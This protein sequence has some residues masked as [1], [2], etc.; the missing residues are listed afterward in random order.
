M[1]ILISNDGATAHYYIRQGIAEAL[2]YAG[3]E[4]IIWELNK[5]PA[6]E[7]FDIFEPDLFITQSYNVNRAIYKNIIKRPQMKVIMKGSDNSAFSRSLNE[8]GYPVLVS[9][10]EEQ[11]TILR[12]KEETG[13]PNFLFCHYDQTEIDI[14]HKDWIMKGIKCRSLCNA[15]NIFRYTKGVKQEKFSGDCVFV[16]GYW[17]YKALTLDSYILPIC[18]NNKIKFK[19]FG[20]QQWNVNRYC[21]FLPSDQERHVLK[22]A[23][24]CLNVHEKHSQDFGY[25][26]IERPY[27]LMTNKCFMISDD[28]RCLKNKFTNLGYDPELIFADSPDRFKELIDY[29]LD[30][31]PERLEEKEFIIKQNFEECISKHTY[32]DRMSDIFFSLGLEWDSEQLLN[33]KLKLIKEAKI[34]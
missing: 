25:D 34:Q 30:E 22:S 6:F 21:G 14:T 5:K 24:I 28:V 20:N 33:A 11:D 27:K 16:G 10:E 9:T 17:P 3:H 4:V 29:W 2:T 19:I 13:K 31:T 1:K 18:S 8:K 7:M 32:F 12:L 23:K 26:V 15:S